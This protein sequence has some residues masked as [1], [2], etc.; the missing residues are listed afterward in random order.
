MRVY[1]WLPDSA[2]A[3][4][5]AAASAAA[6]LDHSASAGQLPFALEALLEH[7]LALARPAGEPTHPASPARAATAARRDVR[8]TRPAS[9]ANKR[10][11][12]S[13]GR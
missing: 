5:E 13:K 9:A 2:S 1:S 11:P 8:P 10:K 4:A 7:E 3:A 12:P 6:P